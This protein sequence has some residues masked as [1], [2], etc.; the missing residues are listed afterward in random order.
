MSVALSGRESLF[1]PFPAFDTWCFSFLLVP[2]E[3]PIP[4]VT[5]RQGLSFRKKCCWL[6]MALILMLLCFFVGFGFGWGSHSA[7]LKK[8]VEE[9]VPKS[10]L[11]L[12]ELAR[13]LRE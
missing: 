11:I 7:F 9:V 5:F 3:E 10:S 6:L 13:P 8:K 12:D 2:V 1:F 4:Q